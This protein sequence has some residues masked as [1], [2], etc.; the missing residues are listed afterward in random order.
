MVVYTKENLRLLQKNNMQNQNKIYISKK[1]HRKDGS[2]F[3]TIK[4]MNFTDKNLFACIRDINSIKYN[5]LFECQ[6]LRANNKI[7]KD[8]KQL[9]A[10]IENSTKSDFNNF[11]QY[12]IDLSDE[13][14]KEKMSYPYE[15]EDFI[16]CIDKFEK[17]SSIIN[18]FRIYQEQLKKQLYLNKN[19]REV[20]KQFYLELFSLVEKWIDKDF[21][22]DDFKSYLL[23]N[24]KIISKDRLNSIYL[25]L[26]QLYKLFNWYLSCKTKGLR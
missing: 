21:N 10:I 11:K 17:K 24:V 1:T 26:A 13:D 12:K 6:L 20:E 16:E 22:F 4:R 2:F 25:S 23:Y 15:A 3:Y 5:K 18:D 7:V 19:K 14:V 9:Q 8:S